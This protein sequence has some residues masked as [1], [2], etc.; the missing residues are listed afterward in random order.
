MNNSVIF[1]LEM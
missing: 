1:K